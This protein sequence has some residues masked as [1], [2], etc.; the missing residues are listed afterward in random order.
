MFDQYIL[1]LGWE[2]WGLSA[3]NVF[4]VAQTSWGE[5]VFL[6]CCTDY[7][8]R[9][10]LTAQS[11]RQESE[12]CQLV[13][14]IT[15]P[16]SHSGQR[17]FAGEPKCMMGFVTQHTV[18]FKWWNQGRDFSWSLEVWHVI[19]L[20]PHDVLPFSSWGVHNGSSQT[21]FPSLDIH[22]VLSFLDFVNQM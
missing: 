15:P 10:I 16:L 19:Y 21:A 3:Y 4:H 18:V 12:V 8:G 14:L 22:Q 2:W 6:P 20:M 9:M 17:V 7:C 13:L 5:D 11:P 1:V